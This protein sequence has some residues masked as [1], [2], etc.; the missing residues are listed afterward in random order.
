MIN[1]VSDF[2]AKADDYI[3]L[4]PGVSTVNIIFN[5]IERI[6]VHSA[7]SKVNDPYLKKATTK[8]FYRSLSEFI[9]VFGNVAILVKKQLDTKKAEK[10]AKSEASLQK[11]EIQKP[12][13]VTNESSEILTKIHDAL[14]Q[15][16]GND[17][18]KLGLVY[19]NAPNNL[20]DETLASDLFLLG[21]TVKKDPECTHQ[22]ATMYLSGEGVEKNEKKAYELFHA[23]AENGHRPSI[24][25]LATMLLNGV[26]V[27]KNPGLALELLKKLPGNSFVSDPESH[28]K[29]IDAD[30]RQLKSGTVESENQYIS[31]ALRYVDNNNFV[32]AYKCFKRAP[33]TGLKTFVAFGELCVARGELELALRTYQQIIK[34]AQQTNYNVPSLEL[35]ER[36]IALGKAFEEKANAQSPKDKALEAKAFECLLIAARS[37][38]KDAMFEAAQKY[39]VK[40]KPTPTDKAQIHSWLERA[41]EFGHIDAMREMGKGLRNQKDLGWLTKAAQKNDVESIKLLIDYYNRISKPEMAVDYS[42]RLRKLEKES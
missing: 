14:D 11:K 7:K 6:A 40:A 15:F 21:A 42:K 35:A 1:K 37:G 22:L 41:A 23:A 36:F 39:K 8:S 18:L 5:T 12:E 2:A 29:E 19:L 9:P 26:G 31:I 25:Q 30:L 20:K 17:I 34:I 27:E 24:V 38:N 4:I 33:Q 28:K 32:D 16:S 3:A 10:A 13:V